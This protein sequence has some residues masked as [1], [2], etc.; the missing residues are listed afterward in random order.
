MIV[1]LAVG[2]L[3]PISFG[4]GKNARFD[5]AR[6]GFVGWT[7]HPALVALALWAGAHLIPNG[8]L[9]SALL[10]GTFLAFSLSGMPFIDRR[11]RRQMGPRWRELKAKTEAGP[12][13]H[14][15][16]SCTELGMRLAAAVALYAGLV[17]MHPIL[18]G[19]SPL[20]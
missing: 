5:P 7:R 16:S 18:F 10:F 14:A 20:G 6:A 3:N 15:P 2:R 17:V 4:G 8:D 13:L 1:A 11:R 12:H 19:I 9:A